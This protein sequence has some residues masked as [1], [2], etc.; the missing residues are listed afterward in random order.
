[1]H[2]HWCI[3]C[4]LLLSLRASWHQ[5]SAAELSRHVCCSSRSGRRISSRCISSTTR[6]IWR[7]PF[8]HLL[9]LPLQAPHLVLLHPHGGGL[10]LSPLQRQCCSLSLCQELGLQAGT[11]R[12]DTVKR[13]RYM[14]QLNQGTS[15]CASCCLV[16]VAVLSRCVFNLSY[17]QVTAPYSSCAIHNPQ[18]GSLCICK[19]PTACGAVCWWRGALLRPR[20]ENVHPAALHCCWKVVS[21]G[22]ACWSTPPFW[23][24][25]IPP[26][27][28]AVCC[29]CNLLAVS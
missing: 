29:C 11:G 8:S 24:S 2:M 6:T 15:W 1:M 23:P 13:L 25:K 16:Q 18:Q 17:T 4:L 19:M 28:V 12:R 14:T 22:D 20:P 26:L 21:G 3:P 7:I 27:T 9:L 5:C 10:L